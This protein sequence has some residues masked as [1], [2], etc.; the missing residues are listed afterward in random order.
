[1]RRLKLAVVAAMASMAM[2]AFSAPLL[3]QQPPA[4]APPAATGQ[5]APQPAAPAAQPAPAAPP[6]VPEAVLPPEMLEPITRIARSIE[7]A[8]KSIQQLKEL[9]GELSRLRSD[10][11]RIIYD[12]TATAEALRPQ[13][14]EVRSQI[15]KLG[16]PPK[17]GEPPE[18]PTVLAERN[19]LNAMAAALDGAIKTT[20]LAWVRAKQLIDRITVIRYQMFARNLL[21]RRDSPLLPGVWRDVNARMDNLVARAKY[22]G[23]YWLEWASQKTRQIT[24]LVALA[25]VVTLG[26]SLL[27]GRMLR[28]RLARPDKPPSFFERAMRGAWAAPARMLGPAAGVLILYFGLDELDLLFP[29]WNGLGS[30]MLKGLL[31]YIAASALLTTA[32]APG[33][34]AWR[35][36]PVADGTALRMA[37]CFKAFVAVYV[38]DTVLLE[39]NRTIYAPLTVTAA[40]S[41]IISII[42]AGILVYLLLSRFEPLVGPDRPVNG[43]EYVPGVVTRHTPLWVKVPLWLIALTIVLASVSGYIALGRFVAHQVVLTGLVAGVAGIAYLAIRAMTRGRTGAESMVGTGLARFGLDDAR[44]RQISRLVEVMATFGLLLLTL[45]V[46]LVQ[47][48]FSGDDIRDWSKALLFGFE[49]GQFRISLVRILIGILLFTGLLFATR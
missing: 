10:V 17:S 5:P 30:V 42:N 8:E 39:I 28:R 16:P 48:G 20:E 3:A 25:A 13:L 7:S 9:E 11:E 45:P 47:W 38:L 29:P 32:L 18:S 12:S 46:L 36:V 23:R 35:L 41:F 43:H 2:F 22:Y 24:A 31:T 34:P 4:S 44:R 40:Q 33:H 37:L 1:M 27:V 14:A 26:I 19:R 15:E 21:E 49:V 6:A